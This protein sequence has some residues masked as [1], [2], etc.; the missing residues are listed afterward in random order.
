M[1]D[2]KPFLQEEIANLAFV[3]VGF[4]EPLLSSKLL[5]SIS[6]MDLLVSI[7][8]KIGKRI[9]QHLISD[10]NFDSINIIIDTLQKI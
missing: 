6:A 7:E 8:E 5:D 3:T 9:P 2:L 1:E 10:G 4:D